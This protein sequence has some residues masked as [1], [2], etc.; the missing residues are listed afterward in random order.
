MFVVLKKSL[1]FVD[2]LRRKALGQQLQAASG[3][4]R[5]G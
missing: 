2:D 3:T 4:S 1:T 5:I